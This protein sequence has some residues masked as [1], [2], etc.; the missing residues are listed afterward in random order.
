MSHA[1][2]IATLFTEDC[3]VA[4][5]QGFGAEGH[6]AYR[7]KTGGI[8]SFSAATSHHVGRRRRPR[9]GHDHG[10][11]FARRESRADGVVYI[12]INKQIPIGHA[13]S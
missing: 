2:E 6:A 10:W 7:E 8:G 1:N 3:Y 11:R 5:G 12:D 9:S 4:Y 13:E